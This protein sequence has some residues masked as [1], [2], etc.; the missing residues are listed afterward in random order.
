[1][2][3]GVFRAVLNKGPLRVVHLSILRNLDRARPTT[4]QHG[5]IELPKYAHWNVLPLEHLVR[6]NTVPYSR[7]SS[8]MS[9]LQIT[10]A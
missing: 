5:S 8:A 6:H 9:S 10:H 3:F 2:Q 1:M 7:W 4:N